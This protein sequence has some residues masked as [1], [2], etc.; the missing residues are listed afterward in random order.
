MADGPEGSTIRRR[1]A[2]L[3]K[4]GL[5]VAL[6]LGSILGSSASAADSSEL[7]PDVEAFV[8]LNPGARIYTNVAYAEGRESDTQSLDL[9]AALDLSIKPIVRKSLRTEDWQRSRFLW[10]R[11][12][13]TRVDKADDGVRKT[14][15]D[16][17]FV[18]LLAKA[19]LPAAIWLEARARTDFRWIGDDYSNR[20][21]FRL[22]ATREFTVR[23]HP[24]VPF[25]KAEW[26]YDTRYDG[27]SRALYQAGPEITFNK[28]FRLEPYLSRQIDRLPDD[29]TVN[30][31]GITAKLYFR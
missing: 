28:R 1:A 21:R 10:A 17:L 2:N 12:G 27:W 11:A 14:P 5:L 3:S 16:R 19:E 29:E 30:A 15:E 18:Q 7:W 22:E 25:L 26:F 8:R 23:G 13:Y 6:C 31:L 24:V 9:T 4:S 20:Y